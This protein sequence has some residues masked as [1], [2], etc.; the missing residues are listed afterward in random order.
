MANDSTWCDDLLLVLFI[1]I[2][3]HDIDSGADDL[4]AHLD[5]RCRHSHCGIGNGHHG[6]AAE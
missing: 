3:N 1:V 5:G 4:G 2:R 6:A